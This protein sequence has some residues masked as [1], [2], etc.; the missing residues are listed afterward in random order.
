[1]NVMNMPGFTAEDSLYK[2]SGHYQTDRHA[3]NS[4]EQALSAIYLPA[5]KIDP[6]V[7]NIH[8][9]QPGY[10]LWEGAGG[11]LGLHSSSSVG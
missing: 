8:G 11:E 7:I 9:C 10:T 2:T 4:P 6:E 5:M 3:I 1:M